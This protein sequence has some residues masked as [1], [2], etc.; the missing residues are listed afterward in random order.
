[1][2]NFWKMHGA[3]NDFVAI[4]GRF[5]NI[6]SNNYSEIAYKLC[7]RKFGVGADGLLVVK[8]TSV[9][10]IEMVYYNSDGSRGEMCGNGI[11]CFSKFVYENNIVNSTSF[12]V[13]TLDGVKDITLTI[14]TTNTVTQVKVSMG[15]ATFSPEYI[16]VDTSKDLFI[17][18][19]ISV[20]DKEFEVSSI[21][22][23]VPHTIIFVD[24]LNK[25]L[26]IKYGSELEIHPIFPKKSNINFVKI[27]D[28]NNIEVQT[29]ERGCGYTLACGTGMTSSAII[30]NYLGLT[31]AKVKTK[32]EGGEVFIEIE[33]D[34]IF[35]IGSAT[36]VFE[37]S[38]NIK[39]IFI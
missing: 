1:M 2:I 12:K 27:L 10:D 34:K 7:H 4:D 21:L 39:D 28:K 30:S 35:M 29:W 31:N 24:E 33:N 16:P 3:G 8:D 5:D 26:T 36:K 15:K 32:S 18:E 17:K 22:M 6:E 13:N 9:A 20:L 23:G 14:D 11:R 37:S 19:K 25:D 38:L